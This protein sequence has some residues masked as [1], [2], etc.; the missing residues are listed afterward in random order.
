MTP[1]EIKKYVQGSLSHAA[2]FKRVDLQIHSDESGDFPRACDFGGI[3]FEVSAKDTRPVAASSFLERAA[4]EALDLIAITDHM[5]SRKSCEIASLSQKEAKHVLALPAIE[6]NIS[7][8]QVSNSTQ[9]GVHLLC[10]FKEGKSSEDIERIFQ[11]ANGLSSYEEREVSEMV[12]IGLKDF[13]DNVHENDGI[14]IASHVNAE[15][16]LRRIF[17]TVA[18]IDYLLLKKEREALQKQIGTTEWTT[19]KKFA[20]NKLESTEKAVADKIQNSYLQFLVEAGIDGVQIQ[21]SAE[22]KF[23]RGEH[24][25]L[26]GIRP[27]AAILTSD[28]HCMSAIGYEKKI[29]FIKMTTPSWQDLKLALQDPEVRIR[30]ADTL[31]V[32]AYPRIR[33]MVLLTTDGYFRGITGAGTTLPQV[34]GFANNL[35]CFIGGRGAGKSAAIDALRF[36]FKDKA[37]VESLP[38]NLKQDIYG[39][40]GH[41][42]KDTTIYLLLEAEDGEEVVIKSFYSGW[43]KRALESRFINGEVAGVD[44]STSTKYRAEIYGWNEIETLGTDS[45]KQLG[46]VDRFIESLSEITGR[47]QEVKNLLRTNRLKIED[48]AK[49]LEKLI[50]TVK[51]FDETKSAYD[52]INT[53]SMQSIFTEIDKILED[54]K[55]LAGAVKDVKEIQSSVSAY[56]NLE[57]KLS[58]IA[59]KF[60]DA[61]TRDRVFGVDNI[62][63]V[64]AIKAHATL[65]SSLDKILDAL[66]LESEKTKQ[67]K[68][69]SIDKLSEAAGGDAKSLSSLDKRLARKTRFDDLVLQKEKIKGEREQIEADLVARNILLAK[70]EEL[71]SERSKARGAT[72]DDINMKL[73]SA[74]THGPRIAIDFTAL[75]DR[76]EFERKLGTT[77]PGPASLKEIGLLKNVGLNYMERRLAEVISHNLSPAEFVATILDQKLDNLVIAHP[78]GKDEIPVDDSKRI[79]DHLNPRRT[80][81]GESYFSGEKL[82]SLLGIQEIELDDHPEITLDGQPIT[83][84]S[85]GQRCSALVPI[86]LLQGNH[87]IIIDQPEDNLDNRLVFDLV[88]GILRNLKESRQIIVATHNPNI[89]VSGDAEQ[90]I[91]FESINREAGRVPVQGSIDDAE[92]IKSVKDIMEG[93]EEAFLTRARKYHYELG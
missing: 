49:R 70:Y 6:A 18:E 85:P 10:I 27:I 80:D 8:A 53:A 79:F 68:T 17:F 2:N 20:L 56:Q 4:E 19:E 58:D 46:L 1:D 33:G 15:K 61:E 32:P 83:N 38:Q 91:V 84:L 44:L 23:Y 89:P 11:G 93:G 26:L 35:T 24:C 14:C 31:G 74:I 92:V 30:Y 40:V 48:T 9:D 34:L 42:L 50:P 25:E 65:V 60:P 75:G 41:T 57:Q 59:G 45:K 16:G 71:Q 78:D 86:I 13:I 69:S 66:E 55:L 88:V 47:L 3:Q 81:Y 22:G 28:A 39:R 29:T 73:E 43:D 63:V 37:E 21:K 72:K 36:V 7:L 54:E 62:L 51:E 76:Q 64:E 12:H 82:S 77:T 90:I 67:T 87:P 5:K 52:K